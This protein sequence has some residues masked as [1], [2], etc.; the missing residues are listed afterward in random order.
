MKNSEKVMYSKFELLDNRKQTSN[1][2]GN[3]KAA[4]S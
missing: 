3:N 4:S 1:H 2:N